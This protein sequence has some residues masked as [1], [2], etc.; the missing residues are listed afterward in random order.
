MTKQRSIKSEQTKVIK[1]VLGD[2]RVRFMS[3]LNRYDLIN[4]CFSKEKIHSKVLR[5]KRE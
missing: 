4:T 5:K 2:S 3:Y 1:V